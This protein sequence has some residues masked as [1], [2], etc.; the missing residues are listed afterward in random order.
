[1]AEPEDLLSKADAL[2]A[3]HW[4]ARTAAEPYAEIPVLDEVVEILPDGDDLP[5]LTELVLSAPAQEEQINALAASIRASL[6]AGLQP[7]IDSLIEER[8]KQALAPLVE[9]LFN[10]LRGDLQ[11]IAREILSDAIGTAVEREIER[12]K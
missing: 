5:V 12:R 6:L 9:R 11:L 4:P 3:R 7:E 1:M 2:M 8:L 10:D